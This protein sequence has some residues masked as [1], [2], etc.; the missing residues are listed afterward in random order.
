M[1]KS[2]LNSPVRVIC[3]EAEAAVLENVETALE[4]HRAFQVIRA[5]AD[6]KELCGLAKKAGPSALIISR[7]F[8]IQQA[9]ADIR[10]L[11]ASGSIHILVFVRSTD[12]AVPPEQ[13]LRLGCAGVLYDTDSPEACRRAIQATA[14]GE[15]WVSRRV[16]SQLARAAISAADAPLKL[17]RR[18]SEILQLIGVGLTNREIADQLWISNE[19]VRWH[20]RSLYSKLGV[21]DRQSARERAQLAME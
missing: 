17:T 19:T 5:P 20:V 9:N 13:Y 11:R 21:T 3:L 4:G 16:L 15:L 10:R 7:A 12:Q 14:T 2:G 18:E 8:L 1:H 6:I